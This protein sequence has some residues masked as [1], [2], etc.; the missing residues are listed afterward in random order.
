MRGITLFIFGGVAEMAEE[1]GS[2]KV[3]FIVAIAGPLVTVAIMVATYAMTFAGPFVGLPAP[4]AAVIFYIAIINTILLVFNMVPAFPLDGGRV[5]RAILWQVKGSLRWA[6][7][8]TSTI[9]SG[10]GLFLM[11]AG[12]WVFLIGAFLQGAIFFF[13]G[14]FLRNAAS[15]S[16]QQLLMRRA[17]EGEPVR[18]FMTSQPVSVRSNVTLSELVNDYVYQT[19]HKLYPVV[20]NG[21]VSGCVTTND[22]KE[23]PRER[24]SEV[25]VA[26]VAHACSPQNT[27]DINADAMDALSRMST[28][29]L[30]RLIVVDESGQ[31]VG[32]ISLKD[33]L[34][35][36]SLKVE[37]EEQHVPVRRLNPT[38]ER[39][40]DS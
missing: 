38:P 37:L 27:I 36:L 22:V 4:A 39:R 19:Y 30:S 29:G 35:F 17:L 14:M 28:N 3:E 31:L 1:P 20:D 16:Y 24:W 26:E 18:R 40:M 7:K 5:L 11:I 33:L 9:G 23:V 12:V 2:P 25:T 8:I 15:M 21:H 6:T 13:I 34:G 10:F 32:V